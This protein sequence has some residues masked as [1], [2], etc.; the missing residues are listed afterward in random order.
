[1]PVRGRSTVF[2]LYSEPAATR[3]V[4]SVLALGVDKGAVVPCPAMDRKLDDRLTDTDRRKILTVIAFVISLLLTLL[5]ILL[6]RFPSILRW[7]AATFRFL[8][9][10]VAHKRSVWMHGRVLGVRWWKL[11]QHDMAKLMPQEMWGYVG[12]LYLIDSSVK[13]EVRARW[14][15]KAFAHHCTRCTHHHEHFVAASLG[16]KMVLPMP[17]QDVREMIADW[18]AAQQEYGCREGVDATAAAPPRDGP[19]VLTDEWLRRAVPRW[20]LHQETVVTILR[21]LDEGR[22]AC[23]PGVRDVFVEKQRQLN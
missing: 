21:V 6:L 16:R 5:T 11:L 13:S 14:L 15:E 10:F 8:R 7:T 17:E 12:S 9:V 22:I 4:E 18:C 2:T 23:A 1:M 3:A 20:Q 19:F